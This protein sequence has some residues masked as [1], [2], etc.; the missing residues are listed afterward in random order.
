MWSV[1]VGFMGYGCHTFWRRDSEVVFAFW[2]TAAELQSAREKKS[3]CDKMNRK[4][5]LKW[6][7]WHLL[8]TC[9]IFHIFKHFRIQDVFMVCFLSK[10]YWFSSLIYFEI[11]RIETNANSRKL[12]LRCTVLDFYHYCIKPIQIYLFMMFCFL[13]PSQKRNCTEVIQRSVQKLIQ[14]TST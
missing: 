6:N 4:M 5:F 12:K 11:P 7:S 13:L 3:L 9:S 14:K 1:A 10:L 8:K 2:K